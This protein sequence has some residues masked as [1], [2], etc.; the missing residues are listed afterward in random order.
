MVE[1]QYPQ[2]ARTELQ[3]AIWAYRDRRP[4]LLDEARTARLLMC[5]SGRR[6]SPLYGNDL[7]RVQRDMLLERAIVAR[8]K[9]VCDGR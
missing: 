7:K 3:L 9:R 5:S 2:E 4:V 6:V 1:A 8:C